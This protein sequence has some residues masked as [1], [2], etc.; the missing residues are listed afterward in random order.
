MTSETTSLI[1]FGKWWLLRKL[2]NWC[3]TYR[4]HFQRIESTPSVYISKPRC[5][6]FMWRTTVSIQLKNFTKF[7]LSTILR[8]F[9]SLKA[10][11]PSLSSV[12]SVSLL[13][14]LRLCQTF[15]SSTLWIPTTSRH[16]GLLRLRSTHMELVLPSQ[17]YTKAAF[18]RTLS[19]MSC[20]SIHMFLR[21]TSFTL[22][23]IQR[24]RHFTIWTKT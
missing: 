9:L 24:V 11:Y 7:L 19:L 3:S 5:T 13:R 16:K 15:H 6:N 2:L 22:H 21:M 14:S 4:K 23:P 1:T 17:N 10:N 8:Q 20:R 12:L 18:W